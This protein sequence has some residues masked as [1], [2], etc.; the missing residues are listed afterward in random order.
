M[1]T[2]HGHPRRLRTALLAAPL[3]ALAVACGSASG[4]STAGS[5]GS[6]GNS[7]GG[8]TTSGGGTGGAASCAYF[9][10]PGYLAMAR[11]A[12][13]GTMLPGRTINGPHGLLVSPAR[14]RVARY[15]KGSGPAVVTV[16][17][18][19]SPSGDGIGAEGIMA[20]PGQ[21]W[22]IYSTSGHLP[23]ET[24]VC[25]GSRVVGPDAATP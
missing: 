2:Q 10:Q 18:A 5:P 1:G 24:D 11:V 21:T 13:V 15:I 23:L 12:F 19:V 22:K 20:H 7:S 25:S 9:T 6:G 4:A 14:V 16:E 17:T 3:A 8:G